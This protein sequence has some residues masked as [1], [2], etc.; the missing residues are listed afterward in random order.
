MVGWYGGDLWHP[1]QHLNLFG[2]YDINYIYRRMTPRFVDYDEVE[3]GKIKQS[4]TFLLKDITWYKLHILLDDSEI[5]RLWWSW[6]CLLSLFTFLDGQDGPK[7][8]QLFDCVFHK[9]L[10]CLLQNSFVHWL[11]LTMSCC[12]RD[13]FSSVTNSS[14]GLIFVKIRAKYGRIF[15]KNTSEIRAKIRAKFMFTTKNSKIKNE[16]NALFN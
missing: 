11:S 16:Q 2:W 1:Q 15:S 9:D 5:C 3:A 14:Y 12:S 13:T 8:F 6:S 7:K 4:F 10:I